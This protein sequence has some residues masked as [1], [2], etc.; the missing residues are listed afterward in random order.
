MRYPRDLGQRFLVNKDGV[1]L[2]LEGL[3]GFEGLDVLEVG[4]GE[5]QLTIS[6]ANVA[7]RVLAVEFDRELAA[8]LM[9][10][11]PYNVSVVIGDGAKYVLIA[12]S[13]VLVS[14]TPFYLSSSIITNAARNNNL[15]LMVLGLQLEV[16]KRVTARPGSE[17]YGRL[18]VISQAYFRAQIIGVMP[19]SWFRPRPKVDAAVVRMVRIR[20]WD[21][22]GEALEK[23]TRCLFSYRNKLVTKA[24]LR[25]LGR[26]PEDFKGLPS[27]ARVRDLA[28]EQLIGVARCL[29]LGGQK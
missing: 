18:S 5:G 20:R 12:R 16:A 29:S 25:C 17:L 4:P 10:R 2:F 21:S 19:S 28:P 27:S 13:P 23:V 22:T 8:R 9:A 24:A 15:E 3:S 14:N 11:V 1:G 7:R 26:V 6:I